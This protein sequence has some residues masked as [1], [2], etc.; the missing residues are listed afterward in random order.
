MPSHSDSHPYAAII[1]IPARRV[2]D[3]IVEVEAARYG[4][5]PPPCGARALK[6]V[7]HRAIG[8]LVLLS[9]LRPS[10][11]AGL[12]RVKASDAANYYRAFRRLPAD[13]Q[14]SWIDA[15]RARAENL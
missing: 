9:H 11:A 4:E 12:F 10:E 8:A 5:I 14:F 2:F 6:R 3:A 13:A 15:V 1:P 7:H